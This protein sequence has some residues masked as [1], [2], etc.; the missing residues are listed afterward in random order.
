MNDWL[1]STWYKHD[2]DYKV[3]KKTWQFT[4][5]RL[6]KKKLLAASSSQAKNNQP[7]DRYPALCMLDP[8]DRPRIETENKRLILRV[9]PL[10]QISQSSHHFSNWLD[11]QYIA[12][13]INL[14]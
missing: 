1:C 8:W 9:A 3:S 13:G 7:S 6:T 4:W 5:L 10:Y 14:V 2:P 12:Y 11:C